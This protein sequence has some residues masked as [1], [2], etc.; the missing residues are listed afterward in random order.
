M[1]AAGRRV[2]SQVQPDTVTPANDAVVTAQ[3][4]QKAPE[5]REPRKT[6]EDP[7]GRVRDQVLAEFGLSKGE[8]LQLTGQQRIRAEIQITNEVVRRMG[9]PR[10][11]DIR[12]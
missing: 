1:A 5:V 2:T 11:L 7:Q 8:L 6:Y 3:E 9:A 12:V 4:P 10:I